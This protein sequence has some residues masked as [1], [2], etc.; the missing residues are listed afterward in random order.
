MKY[1]RLIWI[2]ACLFSLPAAGQQS[3]S[4]L[5]AFLRRLGAVFRP[6][7]NTPRQGL[8]AFEPRSNAPRRNGQ[9]VAASAGSVTLTAEQ[10][11]AL[12]ELAVQ[13]QSSLDPAP[14]DQPEQPA[15][16]ESEFDP[17]PAPSEA[18]Q[19]EAAPIPQLALPATPVVTRMPKL[20][21]GASP[22]LRRKRTQ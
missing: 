11:A 5:Q 17:P 2:A 21:V 20:P 8:P 13:G 14:F 18:P 6:A 19:H 10:Y 9:A 16:A 22:P 15:G 1:S 3:G 4:G 12:Y 7:D